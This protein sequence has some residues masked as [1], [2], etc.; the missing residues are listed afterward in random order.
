MP[1]F[2][3]RSA[4]AF[5]SG[6][7]AGPI[8]VSE[9][10][11]ISSAAGASVNGRD[12]TAAPSKVAGASH[13]RNSDFVGTGPPGAGAITARPLAWARTNPPGS[14]VVRAPAGAKPDA[15]ARSG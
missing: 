13:S 1:W 8:Q 9:R 15:R 6:V 2:Q 3:T 4:N 12:H 10:T 5:M 7:V 14:A 11:G